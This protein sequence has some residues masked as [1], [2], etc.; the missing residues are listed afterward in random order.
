MALRQP[1]RQR[2]RRQFTAM[3]GEA[4]DAMFD[5]AGPRGALPRAQPLAAVGDRVLE[6]QALLGE[7][8]KTHAP[9]HLVAMVFQGEKVAV[10]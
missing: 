7:V 10:G 8:Q 6:T 9:G 4:F 3:A 5:D 1:E 2:L